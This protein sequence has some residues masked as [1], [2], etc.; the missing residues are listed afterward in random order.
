MI[1]PW[2]VPLI[3]MGYELNFHSK[4]KIKNTIMVYKKQ[5]YDIKPW[6]IGATERNHNLNLNF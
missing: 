2:L 1:K 4:I 3:E 5:N 6:Y